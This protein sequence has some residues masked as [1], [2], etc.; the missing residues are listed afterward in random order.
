M[1]TEYTLLLVLLQ[2]ELPKELA[3][4]SIYSCTFFKE[5]NRDG[6]FHTLEDCQYDLLY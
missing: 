1:K 6:S 4:S 5:I 3:I 2:I